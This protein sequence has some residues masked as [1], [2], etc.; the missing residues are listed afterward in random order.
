MMVTLSS[1]ITIMIVMIVVNFIMDGFLE[2][3]FKKDGY[4]YESTLK[5]TWQQ[6]LGIFF[7][8]VV[9]YFLTR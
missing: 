6:L 3:I 5:K 2:G 8:L 4:W 1:A 9:S 7:F